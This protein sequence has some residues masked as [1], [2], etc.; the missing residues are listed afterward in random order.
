MNLV[1]NDATDFYLSGFKYRSLNF[2]PI[3]AKPQVE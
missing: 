3:I 1:K 2:E